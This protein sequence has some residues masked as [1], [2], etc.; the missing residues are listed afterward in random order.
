[1]PWWFFLGDSVQPFTWHPLD[2]NP[3]VTKRLDQQ[4]G[5]LVFRVSLKQ[6]PREFF[7]SIQ[8]FL[9]RVPTQ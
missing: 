1:M 6:Y 4:F 7:A 2:G 9:N 8:S 5:P 3:A